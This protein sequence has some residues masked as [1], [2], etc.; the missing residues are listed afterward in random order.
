MGCVQPW[1]L[2]RIEDED[3]EEGGRLDCHG[4]LAPSPGPCILKHLLRMLS[5]TRVFPPLPFYLSSCCEERLSGQA[6]SISLMLLLIFT[7]RR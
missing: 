7:F 4:N 6:R 1:R 3:D 5:I 2:M